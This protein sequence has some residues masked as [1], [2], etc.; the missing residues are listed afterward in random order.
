MCI[1]GAGEPHG[2]AQT[3][4]KIIRR[5]CD[6]SERCDSSL[7][8]NGKAKHMGDQ[9]KC[10]HNQ[11][12]LPHRK[13][14]QTSYTQTVEVTSVAIK[15]GANATI[16]TKTTRV[17]SPHVA[18]AETML[19]AIFCMQPVGDTV[20]RKGLI[21]SILMGCIPVSVACV[22]ARSR[23]QAQQ[24]PSKTCLLVSTSESIHVR[25]LSS[26]C[27]HR[28]KRLPV[29]APAAHMYTYKKIDFD[30]GVDV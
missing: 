18:Q 2:M 29:L 15:N 13:F 20:S 14:C 3:Y 5:E 26:V 8:Q 1:A 28:S 16:K 12:F 6:V 10:G 22:P 30:N 17:L 19:N 7:S 21:D 24:S 23:S 4:R 11:V 9:S 27:S 25:V